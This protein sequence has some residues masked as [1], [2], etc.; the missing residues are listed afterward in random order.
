MEEGAPWKN[1]GIIGLRLVDLMLR[2]TVTA[3]LSWVLLDATLPEDFDVL[4]ELPYYLRITG[5]PSVVICFVYGLASNRT[6]MAFR[7][8]LALLLLLPLWWT[9]AFPPIVIVLVMGQAAFAL[10]VMRAPF[11]G[12]SQLRRFGRAALARCS[13]RGAAPA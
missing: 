3:A 5:I 2:Y 8:P 13:R 1:L 10:G 7:A 4:R 6:G 11:K 9:I 12:A